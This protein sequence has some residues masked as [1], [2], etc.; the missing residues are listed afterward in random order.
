MSF[1]TLTKEQAK[2][3]QHFVAGRVVTDLGAGDCELAR[4]LKKL[5]A[6]KVIAVDKNGPIMK[7][8]KGVSCVRSY[9]S[10]YREPIDVAFLSWPINWHVEGLIPALARASTVIYLGKTTD[11]MMCGWLTMWRHLS[12]R[13]VLAEYPNPNNTLIVYGAPCGPRALLPDEEAGLDKSGR[14][15]DYRLQSPRDLESLEKTEA[16]TE[17]HN[18]LVTLSAHGGRAT[19]HRS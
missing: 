17:P 5:G 14:V 15:H 12:A 18:R 4:L 1:G 3:V 2:Y 11:G 13:T 9:F 19:S 10:D 16:A 6:S 7:E 8:S